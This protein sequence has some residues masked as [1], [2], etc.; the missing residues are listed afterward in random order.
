[1]LGLI[2]SLE[3]LGLFLLFFR[4]VLLIQ[5]FFPVSE[6]LDD[7]DVGQITDLSEILGAL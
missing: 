1:M 2:V 3:R 4:V 6:N 5:L 7:P